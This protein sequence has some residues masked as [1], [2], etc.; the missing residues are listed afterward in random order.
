MP[1]L[2]APRNVRGDETESLDLR[3]H[4][5]SLTALVTTTCRSCRVATI[6]S[7]P[8][9]QGIQTVDRDE[10]RHWRGTPRVREVDHEF[11]SSSWI[12]MCPKTA[13][14]TDAREISRTSLIMVQVLK[15]QT[16]IRPARRRC[17][18][19]EVTALT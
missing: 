18:L 11:P 9:S 7:E 16:M 5:D 10:S 13:R 1:V 3:I 6:H 14:V 12:S 8:Q 4:S 2:I 15:N 17:S 19:H